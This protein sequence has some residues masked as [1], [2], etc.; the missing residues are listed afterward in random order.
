MANGNELLKFC[1]QNSIVFDKDLFENLNKL[2]KELAI[3]IIFS[4]SKLG[5]KGL[6]S[7]KIFLDSYYEIK[8]FFSEEEFIFVKNFFISLGFKEQQ[9]KKNI[10][11]K[12]ILDDFRIISSFNSSP[13]KISVS[14]FVDMF[15]YRYNFLKDILIKKNLGNYKS[16]RKISKDSSNSIVVVSILNKRITKNNNII[17]DVEDSSGV[18]KIVVNSLKEELFEKAKKIL[19]DDVVAFSVISKGDIF[20]A[21]EIFFPDCFLEEKKKSSKEE[22]VAFISDLHVGS[23]MF[24]EKNFRKF[25]EWV[26]SNDSFSSKLKYIFIIGDC[27]DGTAVY[28][29]QE[30]FL[31]I[32]DMY[33]QYDFLADLLESIRKDIKIIVCPGQHDAVW[34]GEPQPQIPKD[35]ARR[36]YE[37]GNVFLVSNPCLVEIGG[38]FKVLMYHG[39]GMHGIIESIDE[40]R[41]NFGHRSPARVVKEMLRRRLLCPPHGSYDYIPSSKKDYHLIEEIPDI[42]CTGDQ[43][44]PE[45][46]YYNNILIVSSSCW[47]SKTPFEEKVGH[48]PDPCKVPLFNLKTREIKILDFSDEK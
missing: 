35:W 13:K 4:F 14:D 17:F 2:N 12:K 10:E 34:V 25:L 29:D 30:R 21:K 37:M 1:I 42:V 32:K 11:E 48:E 5:K 27:V 41:T 39:A 19:L 26:N 22:I 44:R 38:I 47:Q 16:L 18:G 46:S 7:K 23:T 31:L 45:V 24:L 15:N 36:I 33:K 40:I 3:K 6:I 43:H 28:P 20:F 8:S 9:I